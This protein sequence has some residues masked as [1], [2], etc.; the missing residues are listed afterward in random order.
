MAGK[1]PELI[2]I[3]EPAKWV[4]RLVMEFSNG[5]PGYGSG[6]LV[7]IPVI[8][9]AKYCIMTAGHNIVDTGNGRATSIKIHFPGRPE[10]MAHAS[11]GE[12]FVSAVYGGFPMKDE[13][14]ES[15]YSDYGLIVVDSQWK[16]MHGCAFS[17]LQSDFRG[18]VS[19]HGYPKKD[20][21][22]PKEQEQVRCKF[23][24]VTHNAFYY[25]GKTIAGVS[26]GPVY[27]VIDGIHVAVGIHNYMHRATRLTCHVMLEILSWIKGYNLS[28]TLEE[29]VAPRTKGIFLGTTKGSR[30]NIIAN[31]TRDSHSI[32]KFV[33]VDAPK[34]SEGLKKTANRY[35]VIPSQC[36]QSQL[37]KGHLLHFLTFSEDGVSLTE[38]GF[39]RPDTIL[40]IADG[41]GKLQGTPSVRLQQ[42]ESY[43]LFKGKDRKPCPCGCI[44]ADAEVGL[45]KIESGKVAAGK[46]NPTSFIMAP[47]HE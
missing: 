12:L 19:I 25:G 31:G 10:I 18:E 2:S 16:D 30:T 17:V 41:K 21:Q 1:A 14:H 34:W 27:I 33:V 45:I 4:C 24:N 28:C 42:G 11:A 29:F 9:S 38:A 39:P 35:V 47:A 32:F 26:G 8:G 23:S 37:N 20:D 15:T 5:E 44:V 3:E 6:F 36:H 40:R 7:N 22:P 46:T 13:T 43:L